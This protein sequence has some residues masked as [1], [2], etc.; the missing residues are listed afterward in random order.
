MRV[1]VCTSKSPFIWGGNESLVETLRRELIL[2]GVQVDVVNLPFVWYRK[3]EILPGYLVW[4][5]L[6][7]IDYEGLKIDQVIATRVPSFV[8]S[9]PN[10]VT[11]LVHQLRTVYD[12]LGTKFSPFSSLPADRRL[13]SRIRRI[14]TTTLAESQELFCISDNVGQRLARFNGL[15]A[16]TLYPPPK[17]D[18]LYRND[19]YGEYVLV[20]SRLNRLKRVDQIIR[21]MPYVCS[22]ARLYIVGRGE[23]AENL[24]KLARDLDVAE[25]I[26]FLGFVSDAD[27]L[28]LYANALAVFYAPYDEDYGF[29]TIE[30]FQS[31]KPM[32]STSDAGGVL[33]FIVDGE[34]GY[35][36]APDQLEQIA[37]HID[38][39]YNNRALCRRLG[40]AGRVKVRDVN[41]EYTIQ[42][43]LG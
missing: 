2:R 40:E 6:N 36:S 22:K 19:A 41:W 8:I 28:T 14:D 9:H 35:I 29:V 27:L 31:R 12:L 4:R 13:I 1:V 39:L 11:W 21:A 3:S 16:E 38:L 5:L 34:N 26:R 32:L 17:H 42:K 33:E 23:E 25:R 30:A 18:G 24:Q 43:L 10:K 20:V 7:L 15:H 37:G